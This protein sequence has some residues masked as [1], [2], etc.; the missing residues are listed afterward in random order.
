[1]YKKWIIYLAAYVF[2]LFCFIKVF[3]YDVLQK[4]TMVRQQ[5]LVAS[6]Q[7]VVDYKVLEKETCKEL[8]D[9]DYQCLLRIVQA[10]A[11]CEDMEGKML[12]AGVVLNRVA[13]EHFPDSVTEVVMQKEGGTYQKVKVSEETREAVERV[14]KGEDLTEGALYFASRQYAAGD[15]MAWFDNHLDRLFEHGGHEFFR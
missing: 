1:M 5:S 2:L 11:G 10:E 13:D 9:A 14:L 7:R 15:K 12:V 4:D 6:G 3:A 8:S